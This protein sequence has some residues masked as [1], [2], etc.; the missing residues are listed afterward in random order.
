[1]RRDPALATSEIYKRKVATFENGKLEE[2]LWIRKDFKT[3]TDGTG[4][5]SATGKIHFLRTKL[6][7]EYLR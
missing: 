1:M 5:K 7:G 6:H 3:A 2:F 4:T